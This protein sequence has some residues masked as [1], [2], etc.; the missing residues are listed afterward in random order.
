MGGEGIFI[1]GRENSQ[2]SQQ[3][4]MKFSGSDKYADTVGAKGMLGEYG[5]TTEGVM[6]FISETIS[7]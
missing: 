1:T 7:I 6:I 3:G 2:V 5:W 4:D